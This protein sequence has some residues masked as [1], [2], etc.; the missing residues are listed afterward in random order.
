MRRPVTINS[1][2][3]DHESS[4]TFGRAIARDLAGNLHAVWSRVGGAGIFYAKSIDEGVTWID[5][6]G[7]GSGTSF[8]V[9]TNLNL[10]KKT[11]H[12]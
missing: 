4:K 6:E 11:L 5:G 2:T 10:S 8:Q 3:I 1:T 9:S 12:Q 7:G